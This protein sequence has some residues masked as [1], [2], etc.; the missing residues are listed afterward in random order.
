[1]APAAAPMTAPL[2]PFVV[3]VAQPEVVIS[4]KII[5]NAVNFS[6]WFFCIVFSLSCWM[7]SLGAVEK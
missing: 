5:A 2:V 4:R 3:V 7:F 6:P 1:M